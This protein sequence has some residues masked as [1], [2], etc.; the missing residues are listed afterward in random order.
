MRLTPSCGN[1]ALRGT[2]LTP[3]STSPIPCGR[4]ALAGREIPNTAPR[5]LFATLPNAAATVVR[6]GNVKLVDL[7]RWGNTYDASP[8]EVQ[9]AISIALTLRA[10]ENEGDGK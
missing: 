7:D 2:G 4:L 9:D 6:K 8:K 10:R 5:P 3:V 1:V